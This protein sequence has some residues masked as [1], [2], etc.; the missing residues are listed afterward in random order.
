MKK[1]RVKNTEKYVL[2]SNL[3][4]G[5]LIKDTMFDYNEI[6]KTAIFPNGMQIPDFDVTNTNFVKKCKDIS[7][8]IND[9]VLYNGKLYVI[10]NINHM[11]GYCQLKEYYANV[12]IN[13][14]MYTKLTIAD[15]Y[16][17]INSSGKIST[18][19]IGKDA[20][21]DIWRQKTSNMFYTKDDATKYRDNI[22]KKI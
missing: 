20:D 6:T 21:A 8:N 4:F 13:H 15:I 22:L 16:Y 1:N 5:N 11:N 17:F 12:T 18:S 3:P 9:A 7:F 14:V 2:I 19:Y 10:I